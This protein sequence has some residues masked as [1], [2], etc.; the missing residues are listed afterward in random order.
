M[1]NTLKNTLCLHILFCN[2]CFCI[3]YASRKYTGYLL[4]LLPVEY[5]FVGQINMHKNLTITYEF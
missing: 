2:L 1:F 4:P 3:W 5:S